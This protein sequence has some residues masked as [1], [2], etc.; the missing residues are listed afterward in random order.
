M[1]AKLIIGE[2]GIPQGFKLCN[3]EII[4]HPVDN[5]WGAL[6]QNE[7]TGVYV[8]FVAGTVRSIDQRKAM[9][10]DSNSVI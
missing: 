9:K 10:L 6:L 8:H 5:M 1:N 7:T 4:K 2:A 3:K